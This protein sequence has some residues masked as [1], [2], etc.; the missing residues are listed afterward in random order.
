MDIVTSTDL[1][2]PLLARGKVRDVY[3]VDETT[4]LFVATDR[5]SAYDVVMKNVGYFAK[6]SMGALLIQT[7]VFQRRANY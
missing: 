5:I 6:I 3:T 7:R 4:L 2:L 1:P